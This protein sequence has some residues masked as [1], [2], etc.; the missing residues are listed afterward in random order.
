[1]NGLA[2]KMQ[3]ILSRVKS[4][5]MQDYSTDG[6]ESYFFLELFLFVTYPD[7]LFVTSFSSF[8]TKKR[9]Y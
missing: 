1:M 6:Q 7:K 3:I 8:I 2:P 4:V 5:N 9:A